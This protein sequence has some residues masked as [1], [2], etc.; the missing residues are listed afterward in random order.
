MISKSDLF[1]KQHTVYSTA[2]AVP[3]RYEFA[4]NAFS[5]KDSKVFRMIGYFSGIYTRTRPDE[6]M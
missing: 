4:R 5:P 2:I 1:K 6:M 3:D